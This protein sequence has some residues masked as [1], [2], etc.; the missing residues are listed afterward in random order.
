MALKVGETVKLGGD[1]ATGIAPGGSEYKAASGTQLKIKDIRN[2]GG[3]TYYDIDQTAWGGGTGWALGSNLEGA[4]GGGSSSGGSSLQAPTG[5]G[6]MPAYLSNYQNT[7]LNGVNTPETRDQ[8]IEELKP[9]TPQPELINRAAGFDKLRD[10]YGVADLESSLTNI[11]DQITAEQDTLRQQRGIEEGKPVPLGV[12]AGRITEEER[13][14]N[15]RLDALGRQQDRIVD[16]LNTK[17]NVINT[18]MNFLSLDYQDAVQRYQSDFKQNLSIHNALMGVRKE[19]RGIYESDR[20]A[21][22]ANLTTVMNAVKS[23]NLNYSDLSSG[24]QVMINKLEV[25]AGLPIGTMSQSQIDPKAN[26]VFTTSNN[27]V[28]QVGVRNPDGTVG[29]QSYGTPTNTKTGVDAKDPTNVENV[30]SS[31]VGKAVAI[32]RAEPSDNPEDTG[33]K[34]LSA[35][36]INKIMEK[37]IEKFGNRDYAASV[38]EKATQEAGYNEWGG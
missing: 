35:N 13:V 29:V 1:V 8:L 4:I 18:Y 26:V 7:I 2:V 15:Q 34:Y 17:Y 32:I 33:D 23:G 38:F 20:A 37:L 21:A 6:D 12:I 25:Q 27:G 22:S 14:A 36:E 10:E 31:D 3:K 19:Q 24:Q 5:V 11:K 30:K 28:T 9:N 16:E